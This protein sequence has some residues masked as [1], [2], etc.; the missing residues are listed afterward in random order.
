MQYRTR[1]FLAA[2]TILTLELCFG[3]LATTSA[4]T[5]PTDFA[6]VYAKAHAECLALWADPVFDSLRKK[7]PLGGDT[8]PT[9]QMLTNQERIGSKDK[10]VADKALKTY[11]KCQALYAPALALLP[12]QTQWLF[13]TAEGEE[14]AVVAQLY[15]G[16]I[17]IGEFNA[18][19][20][21]IN[22]NL[23]KVLFGTPAQPTTAATSTQVHPKSPPSEKT[24]GV[25][26]AQQLSAISQ[27]TRKALVVGNGAYLNLPKLENPTRDARAI[28]E[29][30][31]KMGFAVTL[32]LD[33]S[34]TNMRHAVRKFASES[35]RA[36]ISLV[37][38]A[39]H[40]AQ[41][42]GENYL[43]PVDMDVARTEADIQ[44]TGLKVDDLVNSIQSNTKVIFL[45]ACRDNPVLYRYVKGRSA[46]PTGL[47]PASASN[48]DRTK[49]GGGIF[50]AYAT[51]SGSVAFDGEGQHS[52]FTQAL[53]RNLSK[54]VS[55]DDMFSLVTRE[56]RL[57]TKDT[58]RPY[59]YASLESIVCLTG[60][61]SNSTVLPQPAADYIQEVKHSEAEDFEI[62]L[63]TNNSNAL[64]SF[65]QK[66]PNTSRKAEIE[67]AL[68][69]IR[70]AEF[71]EWTLY[72]VANR[73]FPQYLQ[74]KSI[75]QMG[76]RVVVRMKGVP[77]PKLPL[78]GDKS[79]PDAANAE[80]TTVFDCTKPIGAMSEITV[81]GKSGE[82]LSHYKWADPELL[83]LSFV[84]GTIQ[85]K[86]VYETLRNIVCNEELRTP[87]AAKKE[88][89]EMKF[90]SLASTADGNGD[91]YYK[92]TS[93]QRTDQIKE[94]VVIVKFQKD[95]SVA[96]ILQS[97]L[98]KE[99]LPDLPS[100]HF[101]AAKQ[102]INC[103]EHKTVSTKFDYYDAEYKLVYTS[104][105]LPST[106]SSELP[107]V[108]IKEPSP[109]ATLYQIVC[110]TNEVSK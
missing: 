63:N 69:K 30:L 23:A 21:R 70:I 35:E 42:N 80:Q 78:F 10:P 18:K 49:P 66:Y 86:T 97:L 26:V 53:L 48:L 71:E 107:W 9:I 57:V 4:E 39:G 85:P 7:I 73:R 89:A 29:V 79:F 103:A 92:L 82:V 109:N 62:A 27:L 54:P 108:D 75:K 95:P 64:D 98:Q 5:P 102:L 28:A 13:K 16:K 41:V 34:E 72:E 77:D 51:D 45:D 2:L 100:Y 14:D 6:S 38:Y 52:P 91:I 58:Q 88:L 8:K 17:T 93:K 36:D 106:P 20:K 25:D 76:D 3:R 33:A 61:C 1:W 104:G 46:A 24:K 43:L 31:Q 22:A 40:G 84:G 68:A 105:F 96:I 60:T 19:T 59:K 65:L 50:I 101:S 37:F 55:I 67:E 12:Q 94:V 99:V 74:L 110:G 15:L 83:N 90:T 11:Q 56:V 81:F 47:A 44:L 87:L 32:V